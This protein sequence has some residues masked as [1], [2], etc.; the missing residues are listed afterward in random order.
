MTEW[1]ET[2]HKYRPVIHLNLGAPLSPGKVLGYSLR[3]FL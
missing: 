1:F 2:T 3:V